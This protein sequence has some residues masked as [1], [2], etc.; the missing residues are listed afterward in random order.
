MKKID[1]QNMQGQRFGRLEVLEGVSS[2]K[3]NH[4]QCL[5]LC[6]CGVEKVIRASSLRSGTTQSCGCL[7]REQ[8]GAVPKHGHSKVGEVTREYWTWNHMK[9]RCL[10]PNVWNYYNYGGR[11]I[12]VCDRWLEFEAFLEDM[13]EKPE[14]MSID[15]I[16]NDG[17][18][19]PSNCRWATSTEQMNNRRCSVRV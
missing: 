13:G 2:D 5:C 19:E 16:D 17:D 10:N 14:G 18:Y 6:D 3:R 1:V 12:T 15:R 11:G 9:Q 8:S 7:R 4:T